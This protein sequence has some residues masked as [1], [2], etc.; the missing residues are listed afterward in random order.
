MG[1]GTTDYDPVKGN[2]LVYTD[3]EPPLASGDLRC[4][5][6][7][8]TEVRWTGK[9]VRCYNKEIDRWEELKTW[10]E[11][12]RGGNFRTVDILR[13]MRELEEK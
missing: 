8:G 7:G 9:C 10:I 11:E 3:N 12:G 2:L 1:W 6:C 13:K 5:K 4:G